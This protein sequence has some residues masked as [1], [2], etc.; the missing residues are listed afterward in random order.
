LEKEST[1]FKKVSPIHRFDEVTLIL[2]LVPTILDETKIGQAID[3][4]IRVMNVHREAENG[5]LQEA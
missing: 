2:L 4:L 3:N 5:R 1:A